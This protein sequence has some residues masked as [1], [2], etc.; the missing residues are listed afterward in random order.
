MNLELRASQHAASGEVSAAREEL[1]A[2]SAKAAAAV[3]AA[4]AAEAKQ[5]EAEG[6]LGGVQAKLEEALG[7]VE[8]WRREAWRRRWGRRGRP[9]RRLSAPPTEEQSLWVDDTNSVVTLSGA[10]RR[11]VVREATS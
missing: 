10:V 4:E 8:A 3:A 7:Q 6:A 1:T 11:R 5:L 2:A 9:G